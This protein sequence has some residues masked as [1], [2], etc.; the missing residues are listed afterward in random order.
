MSTVGYSYNFFEQGYGYAYHSSETLLS[1][2]PLFRQ[3]STTE[4]TALHTLIRR[5]ESLSSHASLLLQR[6]FFSDTGINSLLPKGPSVGC[7]CAAAGVPW[8]GIGLK[9]LVLGL[10]S[11]PEMGKL[12][13]VTNSVSFSCQD[14][15]S[16]AKA[17]AFCQLFVLSVFACPFRAH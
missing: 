8:R 6:M 3:P 1:R 2:E 11:R 4:E 9:T 12:K 16:S 14:P 10:L 15:L 5:A 17:S 13:W 7:K